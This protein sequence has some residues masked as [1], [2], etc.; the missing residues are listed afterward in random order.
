MKNVSG[1][2][3]KR[4]SFE[5]YP[6]ADQRKSSNESDRIIDD[7]IE[8]VS[9][10]NLSARESISSRDLHLYQRGDERD[11]VAGESEEHPEDSQP[12]NSRIRIELDGSR[13]H[14]GHDLKR[15]RDR[16]A[17][18]YSFEQSCTRFISIRDQHL[19]LRRGRK[20]DRIGD[21]Y[22]YRYLSTCGK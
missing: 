3:S 20:R 14:A 13:R 18:R 8:R 17:G 15:G 21:T 19:H 2:E 7:R 11:P 1:L 22:L 10:E 16:N 4:G 12:I 9:V 5:S 6:S